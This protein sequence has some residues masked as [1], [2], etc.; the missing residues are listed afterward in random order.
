MR[1][2][3]GPLTTSLAIVAGLLAIMTVRPG[4]ARVDEVTLVGST[5][6]TVTGVPQLTF[7][8]N[9]FTG[10]TALGV[11][12]LAGV[13]SLGSF[14]LSTDTL[15]PLS[16]LFT[17][18]ACPGIARPLSVDRVLARLDQERDV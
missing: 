9:N 15:Q 1:T 14:F 18:R 4:I 16:G 12:S 8:G 3:P 7:S 17:L 5:T 10:T 2:R 13:N 6:G 11:G